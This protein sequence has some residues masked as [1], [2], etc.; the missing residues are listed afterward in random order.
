MST[1][2]KNLF[3]LLG[4]G[5]NEAP[6]APNGPRREGGRAP[7]RPF[8]RHSATGL[9]DSEKKV[10]QSW[11]HAESAEAEAATD[12]LKPKDPAAADTEEAVAE[13]EPEEQTK[14]LEEYL[15]SKKAAAAALPEARK[16]NEGADDSKW[17]DAVALE[18]PEEEDF[19][20]GK[21]LSLKQKN[22]TKK[23]KVHVEIEQRFVEENSKRGGFRGERGGR[24]AS[25]GGQRGGQQRGGRGGRRGG[26]QSASVNLDD[27]TAF[28]T[29]GA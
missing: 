13:E 27:A 12:S 21:G 23:E 29:L 11:G 10:E 2:S 28:P 15:A 3:D 9:V 7:R 20:G 8:D 22:K 4:D 6:A 14:T 5:D 1:F 26:R 16:P 24:G 18:K 17:K 25:R 19:F